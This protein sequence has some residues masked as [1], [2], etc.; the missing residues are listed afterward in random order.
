MV[1]AY[2][3]QSVLFHLHIFTQLLHCHREP[4]NIVFEN[5]L[6]R[7]ISCFFIVAVKIRLPHNY[8]LKDNYA[9]FVDLC[10]CKMFSYGGYYWSTSLTSKLPLIFTSS[11]L[12]NVKFLKSCICSGS[13]QPKVS[14]IWCAPVTEKTPSPPFQ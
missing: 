2:T 10:H 3:A 7:G 1:E 9:A 12:D 13:S 8:H 11:L 6:P 4:I 14:W 5:N